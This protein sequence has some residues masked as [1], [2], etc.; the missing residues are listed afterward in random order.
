LNTRG[1]VKDVISKSSERTTLVVGTA[2]WIGAIVPP[3]NGCVWAKPTREWYMLIVYIWQFGVLWKTA[4]YHMKYKPPPNPSVGAVVVAAGAGN[5]NPP[6]GAGAEVVVGPPKANGCV[7]VVAAVPNPVK[8]GLV[9]V[10]AA[11]VVDAGVPN[12]NNWFEVVGGVAKLNGVAAVVVVVPA[13]PNRGTWDADV[14]AAG[15]PNKN[16]L[17]AAAVVVAVLTGAPN[18]VGLV[19][20]AAPNENAIWNIWIV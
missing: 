17:A 16:G 11:V 14:V 13:P 5:P 8:K 2:D 1:E 19:V 7:V 20:G 6:K 3:P 10:A 15:V 12:P 18:R 9:V 4:L